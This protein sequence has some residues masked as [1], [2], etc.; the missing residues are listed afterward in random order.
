MKRIVQIASLL[1]IAVS[2]SGGAGRYEVTDY[3]DIPATG[4]EYG[5]SLRMNIESPDSINHGTM[6]LSITHDN[7]YEYRNL[8]LETTYTD[9]SGRLMTDTVNIELCDA[10]GAW[11][12]T[13]LPG[14]YQLT[15]TILSHVTLPRQATIAVRHIMRADSL[16]GISQVG[17]SF[18]NDKR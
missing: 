13:G 16:S 2:C 7:S 5:T 12:G 14:R 11:H 1:L 6:L 15:D 4:W 17:I 10:L 18:I 8:W 3:R 9:P